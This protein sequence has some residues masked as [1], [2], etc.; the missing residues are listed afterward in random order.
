MSFL[1]QIITKKINISRSHLSEIESKFDLIDLPRKKSLV[2]AGEI[3]NKLAVIES[4]YL[5]MFRT[6]NTGKETTVWIGGQGKFITS[7]SSFIDRSA[8]RWSIEAITSSKL[9]VIKVDSH[10]ELCSKFREWLEFENLL[11]T[12][13]LSALEYRTFELTS[14]KAEERFQVFFERN[15]D[16]FLNV[17]SKYIASMLGVSEETLSRLKK[18]H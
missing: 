8:S 6:D 18:N 5:R 4:G 9:H 1:S 7:I 12:R 14:M 2:Q 10:F 17:P 3:A 13:A 15:A 16:L 11:L